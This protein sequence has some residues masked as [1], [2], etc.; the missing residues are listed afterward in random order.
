MRVAMAADKEADELRD[1]AQFLLRVGNGTEATISHNERDDL[2]QVPA[3]MVVTSREQLIDFVLPSLV[4]CTYQTLKLN[5]NVYV[6][7]DVFCSLSD[8][9]NHLCKTRHFESQE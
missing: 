2:I 1:Y 4:W 8:R 3:S 7:I 9:P 6:L 5:S